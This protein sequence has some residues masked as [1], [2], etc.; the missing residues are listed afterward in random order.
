MNQNEHKSLS[1]LGKANDEQ[2]TNSTGSESVRTQDLNALIEKIYTEESNDNDLLT[3]FNQES[4]DYAEAQTITNSSSFQS[5]KSSKSTSNSVV[6]TKTSP[7]VA[8][9]LSF[10]E[11]EEDFDLVSPLSSSP[12]ENASI[13]HDIIKRVHESMDSLKSEL[14]KKG[15]PQQPKE[16]KKVH[17]KLETVNNEQVEAGR[18][19]LE[20]EK[21]NKE[22]EKIEIEK[23]RLRQ[24]A[25]QL[26]MERELILLAS[27]S[28]KASTAIAASSGNI[29]SPT[30][31]T[32]S[33]NEHSDTD[34][35]NINHDQQTH[36]EQYKLLNQFTGTKSI[37][38]VFPRS[39][40]PQKRYSSD[41]HNYQNVSSHYQQQKQAIQPQ[42]WL[43][44]EAERQSKYFKLNSNPKIIFFQQIK[45][46]KNLSFCIQINLG[47]QTINPKIL[48]NNE[49]FLPLLFNL[50]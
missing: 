4:T 1:H 29:S 34:F 32:S 30:S 48:M 10:E 3:D 31:S 13:R 7:I 23:E 19:K 43:I 5:M 22:K 20:Q 16:V 28:K 41:N 18:L 11:E 47:N 15:L 42:N 27:T 24:E 17:Q 12:D 49:N 14:L 46:L 38:I 2:S 21:I 50:I 33:T 6:M 26:K 44:E 39:V 36:I 35:D 25:E 45:S 37:P 8:A 9:A 40:S